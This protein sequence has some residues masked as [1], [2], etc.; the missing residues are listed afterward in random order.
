MKLA[1]PPNP[2]RRVWLKRATI[3]S[4]G[5]TT[6][7]SIYA[8]DSLKGIFMYAH[9]KPETAVM[10]WTI[11]FCTYSIDIDPIA[12]SRLETLWADNWLKDAQGEEVARFFSGFGANWGMGSSDMGGTNPKGSRL[13]KTVHLSYYDYQEDRF[14][15]LDAEL[16]IDRI[17]NLFFEQPKIIDKDVNYG[18]V[19]PRFFELRFGIAPQGNIMLWASG[20]THQVELQT[21]RAEVIPGMDVKSYNARLPVGTFTL[22]EDR[23]KELAAWD[24]KPETIELIKNGW[25]ADPSWYMRYISVKFP[26]RHALAGNVSRLIELDS[27][28]GS[29]EFE[30]IGA[31]ELSL[32]KVANVMRGIPET[33]KFWFND[34]SGQRQY[35]WLEFNLRYRAG[36]EADLHEVRAAFDQLF[37]GRQLED[38]AY[39]PG[40]DDMA[41][42]E[43]TVGDD[44]DE[45]SAALVKGA[46]RIP[47]PV[48]RVQRFALQPGAHWNGQP[49]PKPEIVRLFQTGPGA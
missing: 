48:G 9:Q 35:L 5:I 19:K 13:P 30:T 4:L 25:R 1:N 41:T 12:N 8:T 14:Y 24:F 36:R 39:M 17:Y 15:R 42:V 44:P 6:I 7:S 27:Y 38:N 33:A 2:A 11:R 49:T 3:T 45:I 43:V 32:Y 10:K 18:V 23:W 46:T 31:W 22:N 28:Q 47:L 37:P 20:Y 40:D 26:W 34:R 16:P 21:Y 29:G